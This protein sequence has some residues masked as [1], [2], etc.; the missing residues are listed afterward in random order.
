MPTSPTGSPC[1]K[2]PTTFPVTSTPGS[3]AC[4]SPPLPVLDEGNGVAVQVFR[5]LPVGVRIERTGNR[6]PERARDAPDRDDR[7]RGR[8]RSISST[9]TRARRR[10]CRRWSGR[11]FPRGGGVHR[12]DRG[13]FPDAIGIVAHTG[14]GMGLAINGPLDRPRAHDRR[15]AAALD[16]GRGPRGRRPP[17]AHAPSET[18]PRRC[19]T[20]TDACST[21][22]KRP[23]GRRAR[24]AAARGPA[25]RARAGHARRCESDGD[26]A[27]GGAGRR[28]LVTGRPLRERRRALRGGA[29]ERS[30]ES[31]TRA[32]S[33]CASARWRSSPAS[34]TA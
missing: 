26:G 25:G 5:L 31:A 6:G 18:R 14:T 27:L 30:G 10:R 3:A 11:G 15:R 17:A 4:S 34:G 20:R 8:R 13:P 28:P 21:P 19:S 1:S 23:R 2:P 22:R 12:G 7:D 33:R 16:A 32:G 24:V 9:G 29:A